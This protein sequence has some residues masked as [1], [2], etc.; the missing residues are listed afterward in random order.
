MQKERYLEELE[1]GAMKKGSSSKELSNQQSW[2]PL[3]QENDKKEGRPKG[4]S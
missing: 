1:Q 2:I 4:E 3:T